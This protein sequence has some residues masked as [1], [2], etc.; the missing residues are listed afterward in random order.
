[1]NKLGAGA[2]IEDRVLL[3][4]SREAYKQII[5]G[6]ILNGDSERRSF[7][8]LIRDK[9]DVDLLA[10]SN[11]MNDMIVQAQQGTPSTMQIVDYSHTRIATIPT[12][13]VSVFEVAM[14][15]PVRLNRDD[16]N[17]FKP[18]YGHVPGL[19]DAISSESA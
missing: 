9:H 1:M 12:A 13:S 4:S 15:D 8:I 19:S 5:V 2:K 7:N 10:L 14:G 6:F 18:V 11:A 3:D 16:D 17:E